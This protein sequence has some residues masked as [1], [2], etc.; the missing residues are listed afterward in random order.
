MASQTTFLAALVSERP[1]VLL[2]QLEMALEVNPEAFV[3]VPMLYV[4][5]ELN[6]VPGNHRRRAQQ[7]ARVS[8]NAGVRP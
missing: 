2:K 5:V 1:L 6:R 4:D 8:E 3:S 7:W